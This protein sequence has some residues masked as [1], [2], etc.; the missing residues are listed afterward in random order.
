MQSITCT[1]TVELHQNTSF[2]ET[3]FK[4]IA[5][6]STIKLVYRL[7][8]AVQKHRGVS[9][10]VLSGNLKFVD[11]VMMLQE[12]I[13]RSFFL[14]EQQNQ[15]QQYLI[16]Q[17]E[18]LKNLNDWQTIHHGW[19]S[20]GII[21]NFEF[22]SHLINNLQTMVR[23]I[24]TSYLFSEPLTWSEP[25]KI[26][27]TIL[28]NIEY[29]ARLRGLCIN[30]AVSKRCDDD[31]RTRINFIVKQVR[32]NYHNTLQLFDE[33]KLNDNLNLDIYSMQAYQ[34]RFEKLLEYIECHILKVNDV[35][36]DSEYLYKA[37][38]EIIDC[39]WRFIEQCLN[40]LEHIVF[41]QTV[42]Q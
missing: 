13:M 27:N 20:D 36:A 29:I 11:R 10:A 37:S 38:T 9:M 34:L 21:E 17:S 23:S 26:S 39:Y 22:H 33:I 42:K 7:I 19:N 8:R 35:N 28:D 2:S 30:A 16:D 31:S 6:I 14:L 12:R 5:S 4:K 15:Q 3:F 1:N 25:Q 18:F 24:E 40:L 32:N 41:E